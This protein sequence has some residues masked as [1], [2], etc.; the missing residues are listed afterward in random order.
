V[1][2]SSAA[3]SILSFSGIHPD[4]LK[5]PAQI[6][7]PPSLRGLMINLYINERREGSVSILDLKGRIRIGGDSA[8]LHKSIRCLVSEG[9]TQILLN[10]ADVTY[11]DSNGL[12][13]LIACHVT[14]LAKGGAIKLVHLTES[15]R[16]LMTITKLLTVFDVFD[17]LSQAV[18][19][20]SQP[21]PLAMK[22][23]AAV[24]SDAFH[25]R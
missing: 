22:S 3:Y 20:F 12:G 7:H 14:L 8:A 1:L 4:H 10:L 23:I 13:E 11:I 25:E 9:K 5:S 18:D 19:S 17:D 15:L 21:M 24:R 6:R 16:E 2:E